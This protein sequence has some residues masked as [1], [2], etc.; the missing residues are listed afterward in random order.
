MYLYFNLN[1]THTNIHIKSQKLT[2]K[3]KVILYFF[4][5]FIA[6]TGMHLPY[7]ESNIKEYV[8]ATSIVG[9]QYILLHLTSIAAAAT[10]SRSQ[11]FVLFYAAYYSLYTWTHLYT[12]NH[13]YIHL[14]VH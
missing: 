12:N 5:N 9:I 3:N 2:E 7:K 10:S 1:I 13:T 4:V 8:A 14:N 11:H 6:F